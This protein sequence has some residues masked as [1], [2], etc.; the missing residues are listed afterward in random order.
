M[1]D[2]MEPDRQEILTGPG[3]MP[4]PARKARSTTNKK[5]VVIAASAL[6]AVLAAGGI[7]F[8]LAGGPAQPA[9]PGQSSQATT[10]DELQQDE[11]AS[12]GDAKTDAPDAGTPSDVADEPLADADTG[13]ADTGKA[14]TG[15]DKGSAG[16]DS[17][18]T[19][20]VQN[21]KKPTSAPTTPAQESAG[22]SPADGPAGQVIGQCSK[23]GC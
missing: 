5:T 13:T 21:G 15:L 19:P 6:V 18:T 23:S 7:G 17:R 22:E 10:A 20:P 8:A 4:R 14:D 12:M 9:P 11:E 1:Q 2:P 3:D 16:T